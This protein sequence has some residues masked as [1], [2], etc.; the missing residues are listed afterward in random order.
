MPSNEG[1]ESGTELELTKMR[2]EY[3]S[4]R[5]DHTLTHTQ[6]SSQLI[7][8]IDGAVLALLY[9]SIGQLDTSRTVIRLAAFPV[10][11]LAILNGLHSELVRVQQH[12]YRSI[13]R[14]LRERVGETEI[15]DLPKRRFR[16]LSSTHGIYRLIHI[17]IA[18]S[19]VIMAVAMFSYGLG[20]FPD[21]K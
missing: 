20:Y 6:T 1:L 10:L 16:L 18:V 13:D 8:L 3:W 15:T 7:Y 12:W 17:V 21:I 14:K 9:F 19:L 4:K 2:V 5:L 11:V